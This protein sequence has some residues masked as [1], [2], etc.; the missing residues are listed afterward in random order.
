MW[1][2]DGC[3]A[4]TYAFM[5]HTAMCCL[6]SC[7]MTML[8]RGRRWGKWGRKGVEMSKL[9]GRVHA[10][11]RHPSL[12]AHR[13]ADDAAVVTHGRGRVGIGIP[14]ASSAREAPGGGKVVYRCTVSRVVVG[15]VR[16]VA[17]GSHEMRGEAQHQHEGQKRLAC[18]DA[19]SLLKFWALQGRFSR[20]GRW[21]AQTRAFI[22]PCADW[23]RGLVAQTTSEF[24]FRYERLSCWWDKTVRKDE[25]S[26]ALTRMG[27]FL[28]CGAPQLRIVCRTAATKSSYAFRSPT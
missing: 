10:Q 27:R 21:I 25:W 5:S 24:K 15:C 18:G 7:R 1:H 23:Q 17:D 8:G 6:V 14:V 2:K 28:G 4:K 22:V 3:D 19:V 13:R 20:K 16:G 9:A 26:T 11:L 12:R